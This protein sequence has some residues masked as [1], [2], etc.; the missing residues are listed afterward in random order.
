ML[1][2]ALAD[3]HGCHRGTLEVIEIE[4][5]VGIGEPVRLEGGDPIAPLER[6]PSIGQ[7]V[8]AAR[9]RLIHALILMLRGHT[10]KGAQPPREQPNDLDLLDDDPDPPEVL[11]AGVR[12]A[13]VAV[14]LCAHAERGK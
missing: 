12:L 14:P 5:R 2:S 7:E 3:P 8:I 9:S 13:H 4:R 10:S 11:D 6:R 1:A